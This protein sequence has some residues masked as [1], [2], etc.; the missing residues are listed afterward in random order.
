MTPTRTGGRLPQL[1]VASSH[2]SHAGAVAS[3]DSGA[4]QLFT[5]HVGAVC[6]Q[7]LGEISSKTGEGWT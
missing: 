7:A 1:E 5:S 3:P 4:R 6:R 2:W